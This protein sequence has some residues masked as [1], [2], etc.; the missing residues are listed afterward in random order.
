ERYDRDLSD[1]FAVQDEIT[2]AVTIAAAPAIADA[3]LHRAI[4][5]P[6][7]SLDAWAAYQ[8]GLWHMSKYTS[9]DNSLAEK[10]F[11]QAIALDPNFADAYSGLASAQ[12]MAGF[13]QFRIHDLND[14]LKSAE[15]SARQA[16][17]LDGNNAAAHATLS[18]VLRVRGDRRGALAEAES[19]L[20][21]S[22]NLALGH[23]SRGS[24]LV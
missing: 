15:S 21:L 18:Q 1:I 11:Q 24:T 23:G 5:K 13:L 22:P 10:F 17:A 7:G 14:A 12:G 6:P 19:A 16:I 9:S 3:E 20:R 4:R 8:R 2:Q